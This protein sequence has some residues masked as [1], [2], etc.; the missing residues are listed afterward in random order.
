VQAGPAGESRPNALRAFFENRRQGRGIWKWQ[1]YFDIYERHLGRFRNREVHVLDIGIYSGGSLEMWREYFGPRARI[2]G[3]DIEP[4]CKRY[5]G[6][7]VKVFIGDQAD[8]AFWRQFRKEVPT[9]DVVVDDGGHLFHQQV[10][11]LEELL[12]HLRPG[13][14]FFCEDVHGEFNRFASYAQGLADALNA[15]ENMTEDLANPERR[16]V[17]RSIPFQASV[18]SVAFYPFVV[19][20]ERNEAPVPELVASKHGTDWQ[21]FLR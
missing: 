19:V 20:V 11:T 1:H 12:P 5:E 17:H 4:A 9:L 10:A 15:Y 16:I 14:V 2:Y 21:P 3:V 18:G 13:G 6:G 7:P 8:R